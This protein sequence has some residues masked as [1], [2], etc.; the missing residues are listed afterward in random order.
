MKQLDVI[1]EGAKRL[2]GSNTVRFY[3]PSTSSG[4]QNDKRGELF[5]G[6]FG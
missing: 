3:R 2:I 1:L 4:L 6:F 5:R